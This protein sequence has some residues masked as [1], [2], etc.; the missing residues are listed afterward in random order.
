MT[1]SGQAAAVMTIQAHVIEA[2]RLSVDPSLNFGVLSKETPS[3]HVDSAS[4]NAGH[5]TLS[6]QAGMSVSIAYQAPEVLLAEHGSSLAFETKLYSEQSRDASPPQAIGF[7]NYIP[8]Q[9]DETYH[10]YVG[11]S[12]NLDQQKP[13]LYK[14]T[15][16]L[17]IVYH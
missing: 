8:L 1:V 9:G 16:T 17:S 14:G 10:M 13:G 4:E 5:F 11:G 15:A 12:V 2:P 6:G 7:S 3:I